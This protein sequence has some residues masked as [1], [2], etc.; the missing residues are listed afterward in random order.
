MI[1]KIKRIIDINSIILGFKKANSVSLLP[2]KKTKKKTKKKKK[3]KKKKK[4]DF[5]GAHSC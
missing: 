5:L 4:R 1:Q 3:K 2:K